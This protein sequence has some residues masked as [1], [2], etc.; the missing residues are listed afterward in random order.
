MM[1]LQS[2]QPR[3]NDE[4]LESGVVALTSLLDKEPQRA[5][6][7]LRTSCATLIHPDHRNQNRKR[8]YARGVHLKEQDE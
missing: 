7:I 1:V 3:Q 6:E 8:T 5:F 2:D 4:K